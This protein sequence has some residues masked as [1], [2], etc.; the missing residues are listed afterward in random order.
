MFP[1]LENARAVARAI[2]SFCFRTFLRTSNSRGWALIPYLQS[3]DCQ[4]SSM[5][6]VRSGSSTLRAAKPLHRIQN[7]LRLAGWAVH[8]YQNFANHEPGSFERR[9]SA[10]HLV[11]KEQ[12]IRNDSRQGTKFEMNSVNRDIRRPASSSAISTILIAIESSCIRLTTISALLTYSNR[13]LAQTDTSIVRRYQMVDPYPEPFCLEQW[14][15]I[16]Q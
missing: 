9:A 6:N 11:G 7:L 14:L 2:K 5:N 8:L 15:Q 10:S 1:R 4:L 12:R 16:R 13:G 3:S